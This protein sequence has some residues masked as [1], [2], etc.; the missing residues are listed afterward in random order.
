VTNLK[1]HRKT[2]E[3]VEDLHPVIIITGRDIACILIRAGYNSEDF[4]YQ[5]LKINLPS[6]M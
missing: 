3:I 2:K 5:W 6:G 4:V 1:K